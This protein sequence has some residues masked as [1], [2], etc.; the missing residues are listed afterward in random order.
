MKVFVGVLFIL[1]GVL[2]GL[3]ILP[4]SESIITSSIWIVGGIIL[5]AQF[6]RS[7]E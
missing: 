6:Q 1:A 7:R 3:G 4:S 2:A 5:L